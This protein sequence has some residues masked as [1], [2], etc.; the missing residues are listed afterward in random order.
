MTIVVTRLVRTRF[1][2][3]LCTRT[4]AERLGGTSQPLS[5]VASSAKAVTMRDLCSLHLP[6]AVDGS[7]LADSSL[8]HIERAVRWIRENYTRVDA[9]R[10]RGGAGHAA[11]AL[12]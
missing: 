12:P 11:A 6:L 1:T 8:S 7:R 3:V 9:A 10:L 5:L 2:S 4:S